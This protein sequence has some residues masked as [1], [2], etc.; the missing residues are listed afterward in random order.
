MPETT[1]T[2]EN[3]IVDTLKCTLC[4]EFLFKPVRKCASENHSYCPDCFVRLSFCIDCDTTLSFRRF[5]TVEKLISNQ[6]FPCRYA[7]EGCKFVG[8]GYLIKRHEANCVTTIRY[9]PLVFYN[10]CNWS[11]LTKNLIKHCRTSHPLN[12]YENSKQTLKC[13]RFIRDNCRLCIYYIVFHAYNELF[14]LTWHVN[15][16]TGLVKWQVFYIGLRKQ[17]NHFSFEISFDKI[18][19]GEKIVIGAPCE[20]FSG[21]Y[22]D[23]ELSKSVIVSYNMLKDYCFDNDLCYTI[24]LIDNKTMPVVY[25]VPIGECQTTINL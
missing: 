17:S 11:G 9:C 16:V 19:A 6:C 20:N 1:T 21:S 22:E 18:F 14:R 2:T 12:F 3:Q 10:E 5:K 13:V 4:K 7:S 15:Y 25:D 24:T 23:M 8:K